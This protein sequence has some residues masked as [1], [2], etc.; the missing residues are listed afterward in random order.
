LV[1]SFILFIG[2]MLFKY[3]FLSTVFIAVLNAILRQSF[4]FL[5]LLI[6]I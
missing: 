3:S 5:I 1:Y 6:C 2:I 4:E